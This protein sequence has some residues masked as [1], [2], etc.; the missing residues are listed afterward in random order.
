MGQKNWLQLLQE[1]AKQDDQKV[2][3]AKSSIKTK[4]FKGT[5]KDKCVIQKL[6]VGE[7]PQGDF[8]DCKQKCLQDKGKSVEPVT[9]HHSVKVQSRRQTDKQDEDW[10]Q[11]SSH[12]QETTRAQPAHGEAPNTPLSALL[13]TSLSS[14]TLLLL[15]GWYK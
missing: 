2:Y 3:N 9:L 8:R 1:R 7:D 5:A 15:P 13:N 10:E 4:A 11:A 12:S 14:P 6:Q